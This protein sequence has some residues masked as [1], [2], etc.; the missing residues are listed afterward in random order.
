MY[1]SILAL[2][3]LVVIAVAIWA[4]VTFGMKPPAQPQPAPQPAPQPGPS[5]DDWTTYANAYTETPI[6]NTYSSLDSAKAACL[7]NSPCTSVVYDGTGYTIR[8]G[9]DVYPVLPGY[10]STVYAVPGA[11]LTLK[12]GVKPSS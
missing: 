3:I 11:N 5:T 1:K 2:V 10:T 8:S 6:V 12:P 4:G 9:T 7:S